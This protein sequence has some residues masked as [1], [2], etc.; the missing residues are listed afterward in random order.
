[1]STTASA[2]FCCARLYSGA[3][4]GSLINAVALPTNRRKPYHMNIALTQIRVESIAVLNA[5]DCSVSDR[6]IGVVAAVEPHVVSLRPAARYLMS[7]PP[8]SSVPAV[9]PSRPKGC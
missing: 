6:P 5:N 7:P 3:H 4:E 8:T 1:M 2:I 9:W